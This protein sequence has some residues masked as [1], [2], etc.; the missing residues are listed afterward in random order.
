MSIATVVCL[1]L[2]IFSISIFKIHKR[3]KKEIE[4]QEEKYRRIKDQL[5]VMAAE[6]K[7]IEAEIEAILDED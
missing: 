1:V 4:L 7:D 3:D 2:L 6:Y 5:L